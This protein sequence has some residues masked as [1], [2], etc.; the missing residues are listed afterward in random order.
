MQ[1]LT[2]PAGASA[3]SSPT[4]SGTPAVDDALKLG[5]LQVTM[6]AVGRTSD[7][8]CA[9]HRDG[10]PEATQGLRAALALLGSCLKLPQALEEQRVELLAKMERTAAQATSQR[11]PLVRIGGAKIIREFNPRFEDGYVKV[12]VASG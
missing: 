10:Y 9:C 6:Q 4:P 3:K 12:R 2:L 8:A 11:K 5:L 1:A 7:V